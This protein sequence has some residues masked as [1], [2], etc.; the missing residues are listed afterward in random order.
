M[1]FHQRGKNLFVNNVL[2]SSI[3]PQHDIRLCCGVYDPKSPE[4]TVWFAVSGNLVNSEVKQSVE[5]AKPQKSLQVW[6]QKSNRRQQV[7]T[8]HQKLLKFDLCSPRALLQVISKS[9]SRTGNLQGL[10]SGWV[11][12]YIFPVLLCDLK[13]AWGRSL[14]HQYFAQ[15]KFMGAFSAVCR[16]V[17]L[18]LKTTKMRYQLRQV[19]HLLHLS[20]RQTLGQ[21]IVVILFKQQF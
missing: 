1:T 12:V 13:I 10:N 4:F 16:A 15:I 21:S 18:L 19:L 9:Q 20:Y 14:G 17:V 6:D 5:H 8:P 2:L 11:C 3:F 7:R